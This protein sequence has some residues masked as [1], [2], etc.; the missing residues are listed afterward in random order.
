LPICPK[1]HKLISESH[2]ERHL[3]RCGT[4]R[5]HEPEPQALSAA[6]MESQ[7][8]GTEYGPTGTDHAGRNWKKWL[9]V[10]FIIFL[11]IGSLA[12]FFLLYVVSL[13]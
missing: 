1:C 3:R 10:G 2:Y 9:V 13:L 8:G 11:L 6:A 5:E 4:T 12:L 7:E